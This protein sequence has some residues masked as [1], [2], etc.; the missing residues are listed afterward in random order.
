MSCL[1]RLR[2]RCHSQP[3]RAIAPHGAIRAFLAPLLPREGQY[4][5]LFSG[6]CDGVAIRN[7]NAL[8]PLT[9]QYALFGAAIAPQGA[10]RCAARLSC[11]YGAQYAAL[12]ARH[13]PQPLTRRCRFRAPRWH[14]SCSSHAIIEFAGAIALFI[15]SRRDL[16]Y[17]QRSTSFIVHC[18]KGGATMRSLTIAF[19]LCCALFATQAWAQ[20]SA[21]GPIRYE[22]FDRHG[23]DT[24][25]QFKL[26]ANTTLK[27]VN[28][29]IYNC[30]QAPITQYFAEI[31]SGDSR[32]I[33]WSQAEG[34][35]SCQF[36]ITGK[37]DF[38]NSINF[39]QT[40]TFYA[41]TPLQLDVNLR[42]LTPEMN[43]VTLHASK[44][45]T[46]ASITVT[47]EDGSHIDTVE[48]PIART[49][50]HKLVWKPN[51]KK[52]AMLEIKAWDD[53]NSWASFTIFYFQ[54]PHTDIVFDTAKYEV[55]RDQEHHLQE[56]LD[57]ILEVIQTHQRVAVDLYITG[58]TD[59]VGSAASNDKLS[60]NRAKAIASWFRKHGLSIPTFYRGAGERSLAVPTP[61][62][63]PNEKNRR[64]V[65]ILS[66]RPPLDSAD[67]GGFTKL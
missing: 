32:L 21:Q 64:A 38:G 29:K 55:R 4:A 2:W 3:E 28:V 62:N 9:G 65:Y 1:D 10:I 19:S 17:H 36:V 11:P 16:R 18:P 60:L 63:T 23:V 42:E 56:S 24:P 47:A 6:G 22:V 20:N 49:K 66:N 33:Q 58:Y 53:K 31:R 48:Q 26:I 46:R 35:Y 5:D 67:L 59:T 52:P 12:F 37:N 45:M 43:D 44:P 15:A 54:I 27:D 50:T 57:K 7:P 8:L 25:A 51:D 14:A 13:P 61:D 41:M 39:N 34:T 30:G 40:H